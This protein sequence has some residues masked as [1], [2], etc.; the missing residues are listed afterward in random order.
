[1]TIWTFEST[2]GA[3]RA[4]RALEGLVGRRV[5]GVADAAV[6]AWADRDRRPRTY[7]ARSV[8]GS[9]PLAGAFWG[10]L[11]G[12]AFL[13]PLAGG[14]EPAG[15]S[16]IGLTDEFLHRLRERIGPGTSAL[17]LIEPTSDP[18]GVREA[19]CVADVIE[20]DLSA[21]TAAALRRAFAELPP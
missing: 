11:F 7:Q 10:L 21:E 4:L 2:D 13:R 5:I 14:V 12:V 6:V 1:V 3:E 18:D 8:A 19:L 17:F 20:A 9:A 16:R 15:L